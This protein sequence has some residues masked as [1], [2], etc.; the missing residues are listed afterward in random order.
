MNKI[1]DTY[2]LKIKGT[3]QRDVR[4]SV[5]LIIRTCLGNWIWLIFR[6]AIQIFRNLLGK[7]ISL[8]GVSCILRGVNLP[9]VSYLTRHSTNIWDRQFFFLIRI[10]ATDQWV[11]RINQI[12]HKKISPGIILRWVNLCWVSYSAE[13]ISPGYAIRGS[14][15]WTQGVNSQFLKCLHRP[16]KG[17]CHKNKCGTILY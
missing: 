6:R 1:V 5:F 16:L 13:S 2:I 4:S 12:F 17:Q 7:S 8:G 11:D 14:H 15:S 3:V 10:W 9:R